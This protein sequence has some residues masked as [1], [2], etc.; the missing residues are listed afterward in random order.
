MLLACPVLRKQAG[1]VPRASDYFG[2]SLA[3]D[4]HDLVLRPNRP[5]S[6]CAFLDQP[7]PGVRAEDTELPD[8]LGSVACHG[9]AAVAQVKAQEIRVVSAWRGQRDHVS[10]AR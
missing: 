3:L 8:V 6:L 10:A 5:H 1:P 9:Y 7:G 4:Q 2:A